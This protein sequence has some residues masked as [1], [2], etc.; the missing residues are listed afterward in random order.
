MTTEYKLEWLKDLLAYQLN[1]KKN[2]IGDRVQAHPYMYRVQIVSDLTDK[3]KEE[4][5]VYVEKSKRTIP[6]VRLAKDLSA[7]WYYQ[8]LPQSSWPPGVCQMPTTPRDDEEYE[9]YV[10]TKYLLENI[11]SFF[12]SNSKPNH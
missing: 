7:Q 6:I 11:F 4:L 1:Y 9:L 10:H 8:R 2:S 3:T 12:W 5:L